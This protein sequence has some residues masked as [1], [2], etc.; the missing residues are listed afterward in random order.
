MNTPS[1]SIIIPCRNERG[2]IEACVESIAANGF[3]NGDLEVLVIDAMSTDGTRQLLSEL[4]VRYPFMRVVDNPSGLT[5]TGLNLGIRTARGEV[6]VRIDGHSTIQPGYLSKCVTALREGKADNVGGAMLTVPQNPSWIGRTVVACLG[7]SFGVGDSHFR[8]GT[9]APVLVDTVFGGCFQRSL[10]E[11]MGYFNEKLP[12]GQD[13]EFNRR[14]KMRGGRILLLPDA[15]S[16]YH[17]RSTLGAFLRHNWT[18]GVWAILP[19]LYSD[20]TPVSIRHLVPLMFALS[21]IVALGLWAAVPAIGIWAVAAVGI[22]YA[23][24]ALL[25]S[26]DIGRTQRKPTIALL[27]PLV[28]LSLH[29]GYGFGSCWGCLKAFGIWLGRGSDKSGSA[30]TH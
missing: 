15:V 13:M 4:S 14:L 30:Q 2:F 26:V 20:V 5:P 19:F 28:F 24:A 18:N 16:I 22:P 27:A 6:I 7:H 25:S 21:L 8:T 12:R 11:Q 1:V 17:A 3:P 10:F 9:S 29:L 23:A